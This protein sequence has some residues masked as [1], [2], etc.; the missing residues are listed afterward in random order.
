[1][2][3]P[4]PPDKAE[5]YRNLRAKGWSRAAACRHLQLSESW[6][7]K[8]EKGYSN[9]GGAKAEYAEQAALAGPIA[10]DALPPEALKALGDFE[11]FRRR[12]L[13]HVSTP[14]QVE[15]AHKL[16][17]LRK[18]PNKEF[19]VENCP[20]GVG[21]TTLVHDI[22]CWFTVEDRSIRGL[23]GT[24]KAANGER[25]LRRIKRSLER[26]HPYKA[27][28]EEVALGLSVDAE[29]T[30]AGDFGKFK[31]GDDVWRGNEF[32]VAQLDDVAV[33]EKEPTWSSYGVDSGVLGNRFEVIF[34]DDLVDRT[35][36]R[37]TETR[38]GLEELWDAEL[39]TRLEPGGL[40]VL[41]GQRLAG[42]DLY[43]FCRNKHVE[44][45]EED[46]ADAEP[47]TDL[48]SGATADGLMYHRIV[49]PAHDDELCTG[50]HKRG[51]VEPWPKGC[52]LDPHRLPWRDLKRIR[53]LNRTTFEVTYQQGD[54]DPEGVLVNPIW[55][56][57]GKDHEGVERPGCWDYERG[58]GDRP[59]GAGASPLSVITVD[60]SPTKLW[61]VQWWV[62]P[63]DTAELASTLRYLMDVYR[64]K[65]T[66]PEFMYAEPTS[67]GGYLYTG[68]LEQWRYRAKDLGL[69]LTHVIIE[70]NAAQR[71]F[72]QQPY[73]RQWCIENRIAF[74]PH[75]THRNKNDAT[76]GVGSLGQLWKFG[77]IRLPGK[78]ND[79]G[80]T[81]ALKL[82]DE[83]QKWPGG[84]TDDCVMAH[85][86]HEIAL[87]HIA[88]IDPSKVPVLKRPTWM[89]PKPVDL[90]FA[91]IR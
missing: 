17:E 66:A 61:S 7:F 1:M 46:L 69:P 67:S 40:L 34:W 10:P 42:G 90:R 19:V 4:V 68:M 22:A 41:L 20:P 85:W 49:Y 30:L 43:A 15:T 28:T 44:V 84:S 53:S 24:R 59:L 25:M 14:W 75:Q 27:P 21:K 63:S 77:L 82:V 52:L 6:A 64:Q 47:G 58:L 57:G 71:F 37:S 72:T 8:H 88:T 65:M 54:S 62:T 81:S 38:Q 31:P 73:F 33:E 11:Y 9:K 45:D 39:E 48:D 3:A 13:G 89:D 5:K 76:Y 78:P 56:K 87:P 29:A 32:F 23:I 35:N 36:T 83:V 2:P 26:T 12:Y 51:T 55:V 60:P 50:E 86:F 80:R 16:L 70:E 18:T 91:G 74:L 79:P